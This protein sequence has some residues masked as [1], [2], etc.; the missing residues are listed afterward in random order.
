MSRPNKRNKKLLASIDLIRAVHDDDEKTV[1]ELLAITDP[2][3]QPDLEYRDF[4]A[5][6][7]AIRRKNIPITRM[8]ID[9]GVNLNGNENGLYF[10]Y[11]D[12]NDQA[13]FDFFNFLIPIYKEKGRESDID[14]GFQHAYQMGCNKIMDL[15]LSLGVLSQEKLKES[16]IQFMDDNQFKVFQKI[17]N[18]AN[19]PPETI[20]EILLNNLDNEFSLSKYTLDLLKSIPEDQFTSVFSYKELIKIFLTGDQPVRE[21][22]KDTIKIYIERGIYNVDESQ[23]L[24][25][26]YQCDSEAYIELFKFILPI[27]YENRY[28]DILGAGFQHA[29]NMDCTK[30]MSL[31]MEFLSPQQL[32]YY[33]LAAMR[34]E[35]LF[36]FQQ[37]VINMQSLSTA[38]E[39]FWQTMDANKENY[40]T[41]V[42]ET[43]SYDLSYDERHRILV[44]AA[45]KGYISLINAMRDHNVYFNHDTYTEANTHSANR[46]TTD[47]INEIWEQHINQESGDEFEESENES[48]P[49][50]EEQA[51]RRR[52]RIAE[53]KTREEKN[54]LIRQQR[55]EEIKSGTVEEE[56]NSLCSNTRN[57][58]GDP[59]DMNNLIVFII[60]DEDIEKGDDPLQ[61]E[62]PLGECYERKEFEDYYTSIDEDDQIYIWNGPP[63]P[64][65]YV[66]EEGVTIR[67]EKD[68]S[69]PV[70]KL[71]YSGI[72]I[73]HETLEKVLESINSDNSKPIIN[74]QLRKKGKASIG[75]SFGVSRLHGQWGGVWA[76]IQRGVS[77][78]A[79]YVPEGNAVPDDRFDIYEG[80]IVD[81]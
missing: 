12:C 60:V 31:Y 71:A 48:E 49:E 74:I 29:Y 69:K 21:F 6:Q 44:K 17:I 78:D 9:A 26:E 61:G 35:K 7:D 54:E 45:E 14:I 39:L 36:L 19:F 23:L 55:I 57:F 46:E 72:W 24:F 3:K 56:Q 2:E 75:S 5:F 28:H 16:A 32:K 68:T 66:N 77:I 76:P 63:R 20:K 50:T 53:A 22:V 4:E 15:Y 33:A 64:A 41:F 11:K 10:E 47:A 34:D 62:A 37:L 38:K 40:T 51:N 81:V 27:Y 30:I 73:D 43:I 58:L 13:L 8:F 25:P 52:E 80:E 42:F 59:L 70:Y 1:A 18:V 67:G 79:Q 65:I